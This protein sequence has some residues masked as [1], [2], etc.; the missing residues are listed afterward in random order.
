MIIS[1]GMRNLSK[2]ENMSALKYKSVRH[3]IGFRAFTA[4]ETGKP[5]KPRYS[6]ITHPPASPVAPI[7][8]SRHAAFC[9][10]SGGIAANS[11]SGVGLAMS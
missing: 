6:K 7:T 5:G 11:G 8:S 9:G 3:V 10:I 2:T 1:K 4:T